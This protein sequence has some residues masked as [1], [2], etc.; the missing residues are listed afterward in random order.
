[1]DFACT[2]CT[3]VHPS[4]LNTGAP[5]GF[6]CGY[7]AL[8]LNMEGSGTLS[9]SKCSWKE[10]VLGM[11]NHCPHPYTALRQK[12][13]LNTLCMLVI[14]VP[15]PLASDVWFIYGLKGYEVWK[16]L[17]R[18]TCDPWNE[19]FASVLCRI[20][21]FPL[22]DSAFNVTTLNSSFIVHQCS[23]DRKAMHVMKKT[24]NE[25]SWFERYI[26]FTCTQSV[27]GITARK[28]SAL[29]DVYNVQIW[30]I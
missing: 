15:D 17:F 21:H 29:H 24:E 27:N 4:A 10:H 20:I 18:W 5:A 16:I 13:F 12:C 9:I 3:V 23:R 25:F 7:W 11:W 14:S 6:K 2:A 30:N 8:D 26:C 1:M 28:D 22:H 19:Y